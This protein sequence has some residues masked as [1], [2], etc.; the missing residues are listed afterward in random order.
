M[1]TLDTEVA[2][3]AAWLQ[4]QAASTPFGTIGVSLTLHGGAVSKVE[5]IISETR[6]AGNGDHHARH[7][8]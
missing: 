2:A 6:K 5:R 7:P 4:A 1:S 8:G 3:A